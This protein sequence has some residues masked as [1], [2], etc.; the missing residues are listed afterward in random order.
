VRIEVGQSG[1]TARALE[2][3]AHG[4]CNRPWIRIN[5]DCAKLEVA[6]V[7]DLGLW[8]KWIVGTEAIF[9]SEVSPTG[10]TLESLLEQWAR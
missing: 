5:R 9:F 2:D 3:F 10:Q 4:I 8:K 7:R 1:T 6:A